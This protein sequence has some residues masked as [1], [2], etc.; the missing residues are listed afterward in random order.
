MS[1][2][3]SIANRTAVGI[4]TA[5][6][7]NTSRT[8]IADVAARAPRRRP[9]RAIRPALAG[10]PCNR[11]RG[12]SKRRYLPAERTRIRAAKRVAAVGGEERLIVRFGAVGELR[13][14]AGL[15]TEPRP[16]SR[17]IDRAIDGQSESTLVTGR[18]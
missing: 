16:Q 15:P 9:R 7:E 5:A 13:A 14:A 1:R 17:I 12:S 6:C 10:S 2:P 8:L 4:I 11:G 3:E 18:D